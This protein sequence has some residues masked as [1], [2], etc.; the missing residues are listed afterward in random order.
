MISDFA[1]GIVFQAFLL[2]L[3]PLWLVYRIAP[4]FNTTKRVKKIKAYV[5]EDIL[6]LL[7]APLPQKGEV[8]QPKEGEELLLLPMLIDHSRRQESFQNYTEEEQIKSIMARLLGIAF[9]TIDTTTITLTHV[10]QDMIGSPFAQYA[11]P[12]QEQ[13]R[14]VKAA[15]GGGE[16]SVKSL[17]DLTKLDSFVKE[18]Q[19]LRPL[20]YILAKRMVLPGAGAVFVSGA[21]PLDIPGYDGATSGPEI[22]VPQ[23]HMV[24]MPTWGVHS[25]DAVYEDAET[26][27]GFRFENDKIASSQPTDRF[28]SF[29]HGMFAAVAIDEEMLIKIGRHACPGRHV[30]LSIIKLFVLEFLDTFE[31]K[32]G[33]ERLK[34]WSF[35]TACVPDM[36]G[37]VLI[38]RKK[39]NHGNGNGAANGFAKVNGIV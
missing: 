21:G 29:G 31:Y 26:F 12:I 14:Q 37:R 4:F 3:L 28:L 34:A 39:E 20:G 19:R 11:G 38:R 8:T 2:R 16:W 9:A 22:F 10:M 1:Q 5:R 24:M 17:S 35:Q 32:E 27:K 33:Q 18:V 7:R 15:N 13:A 36:D 30:A 6:A 25:D 23:N